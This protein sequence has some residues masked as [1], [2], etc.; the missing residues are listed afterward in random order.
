MSYSPT[1]H[2]KDSFCLLESLEQARGETIPQASSSQLSPSQLK[3]FAEKTFSLVSHHP[4][5]A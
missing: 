1:H 5:T 4:H 2:P 3:A